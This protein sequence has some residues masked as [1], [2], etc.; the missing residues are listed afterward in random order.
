MVVKNDPSA[1]KVKKGK[2]DQKEKDNLEG[3]LLQNK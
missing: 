2:E 1:S 3:Y